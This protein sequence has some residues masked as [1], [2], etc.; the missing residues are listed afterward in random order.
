M[1]NLFFSLLTITILYATSASAQDENVTYADDSVP[2]EESAFDQ[3]NIDTTYTDAN[4][5]APYK[6]ST[7]QIETD[8]QSRLWLKLQAS[9][10][11]AGTRYKLPGQTATQTYQRYLKSFTHP[12][13]LQF[14]LGGGGS[15]TSGSGSSGMSS[16]R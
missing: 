15:G 12:I 3:A 2:Y 14:N 7:I 6:E 16:V 5:I 11:L 1:R 4:D 10:A 13:P 8:T 9:G